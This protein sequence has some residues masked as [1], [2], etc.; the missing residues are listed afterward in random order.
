MTEVM[1]QG[2]SKKMI[3]RLKSMAKNPKNKDYLDQVYY[4]IGN[5]YLANKDTLHAIW[6]Y[7]DGVEKSTRNG[8]NKGV[9]WLHLGQLY[10]EKEEFVKAKECY[11]GA[12]GLFDKERED[13]KAVDERTKILEELF[14]HASAVEL[15]DSLQT[16]AKMDSTKRMEV[17]KKI[18]EE[19]KKKEKEE[20]K[21]AAAASSNTSNAANAARTAA[22]QAA[23][24]QMNRNQQGGVWYFYNPTAITSGASEFEK[25]WGKRELGDDWNRV[26]KTVLADEEQPAD[27]E[28]E[29]GDDTLDTGNDSIPAAGEGTEGAGEGQEELSEE[30]KKALEKQDKRW[31]RKNSRKITKSAE[32]Q[33]KRE[34]KKYKKKMLKDPDVLTK[35]GKLRASAMNKYNRHMAEVMSEKVKDIRTPSGQAVSFVAKR[36]QMGV[37]MAISTEGYDMSKF[38]NGIYESGRIAYRKDVVNKFDEEG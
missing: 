19:V 29:E 6:A 3:H 5:I 30:E 1:S 26:N 24:N 4:A 32:R 14:P 23:A 21:K 8:V 20:A 10:W 7:K 17:I 15:Q 16:L 12:L 38:K 27:E 13:Y 35:K 2:Q 22:N 25:K 36:G 31:V 37:Y 28:G 33:S 18:I 11:S 9:V 34:L